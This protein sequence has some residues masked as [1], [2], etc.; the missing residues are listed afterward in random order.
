M[1]SEEIDIFLYQNQNL[2]FCKPSED[3]C[4][5]QQLE[6]YDALNLAADRLDS[7]LWFGILEDLE[8][9]LELLKFQIDPIPVKDM[10]KIEFPQSNSKATKPKISIEDRKKLASLMP[11]DRWIYAYALALFEARWNAYKAGQSYYQV[12][13]KFRIAV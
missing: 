7:T 5:L 3:E 10:D 4:E 1:K 9:S 8:R 13:P 12:N 2:K 11:K 6:T